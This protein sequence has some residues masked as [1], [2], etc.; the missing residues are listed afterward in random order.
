MTGCLRLALAIHIHQP[1]GN[2][3]GVF[4]NAYRDSYA[5]LLEVLG[6]YPQVPVSLHISGSLLEWLIEAHGEYIDTVRSLTER[7]QIEIVGGPFYEP[8][9]A[10]IPAVDRI[11]QISAYSRYL[12]QLFG[13][14]VRGAWVPERV[15]EQAFVSDLTRAGIEY[16][17]L[18]DYHF[19][20]A[21]LR[22]DE[23]FG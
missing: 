14:K 18:D 17:I 23:L 20:S 19:K 10:A 1:V 7:G 22:D 21:G 15:W 4:E 12:E 6:R 5:P 9:L 2:F 13:A 8:I 16:T 3:S 11:G